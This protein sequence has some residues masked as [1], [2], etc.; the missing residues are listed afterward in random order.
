MLG[1]M[2]TVALPEGVR[3][4]GKP[5]TLQA[6]LYEQHR[7]EVPI[8]EFDERWWVRVSCQIYNSAGQYT[9]FADAVIEL[10]GP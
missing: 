6:V 10:A 3:R 5:D 8:M 4:H 7:I 9:Q 2:A 1:S